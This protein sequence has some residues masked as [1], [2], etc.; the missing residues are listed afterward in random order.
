MLAVFFAYHLFHVLDFSSTLQQIMRAVT[1]NGFQLLIVCGFTAIIIYVYALWAFYAIENGEWKDPAFCKSILGCFMSITDSIA[2]GDIE[3]AMHPA[4]PSWEGRGA[5]W[6]YVNRWAFQFSF[7]VVVIVIQLNMIFGIILDT[8]SELRV[9][10]SSKL[11]NMQNVCFVCGLDRFTFDTKSKK[12]EQS[13]LAGHW[14]DGF[15][16][17]IYEDHNMWAYVGMMVHV[18]E[19][20]VTEFNG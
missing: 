12:A 5:T 3:I 19:K 8:F 13:T 4:L 17:H 14:A 9:V 20:D 6:G 7:F 10:F 1:T 18:I 2:N 11:S 16:R 15:E